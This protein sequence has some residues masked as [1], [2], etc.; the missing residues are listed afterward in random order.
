MFDQ[1]KH[2]VFA[3][4]A[5]YAGW[6][7]NRTNRAAEAESWWAN[8]PKFSF[9]KLNMEDFH[10]EYKDLTGFYDSAKEVVS[11]LPGV[12]TGNI[13]VWLVGSLIKNGPGLFE[14]GDDKEVRS[15]AYKSTT[16]VFCFCYA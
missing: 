2:F 11:P 4:L 10:F 16:L 8:V 12:L 3:A 7:I 6:A 14:F 1:K 15:D 9:H 5:L 13:P